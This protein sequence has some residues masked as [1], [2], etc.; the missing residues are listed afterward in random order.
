MA[1]TGTR[2]PKMEKSGVYISTSPGL[3]TPLHPSS[4]IGEGDAGY[5][6][7]NTYI[8]IPL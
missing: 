7:R 8:P 6:G 3:A 1:Y 4:Q 2:M 5:L